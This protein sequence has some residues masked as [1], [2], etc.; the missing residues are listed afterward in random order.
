MCNSPRDPD[1]SRAFSHASN[2]ALLVGSCTERGALAQ[3][4]V[5]AAREVC[6]VSVEF[7]TLFCLCEKVEG[8]CGR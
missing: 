7:S 1:V 2:N 3:A 4:Q 5:E 6:A 8:I